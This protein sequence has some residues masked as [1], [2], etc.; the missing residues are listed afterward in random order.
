[1]SG[2]PVRVGR[3]GAV[4]VVEID[5]P[6]VNTM[7]DVVLEGLADA[8]AV[9]AGDAAVRA[10]VLTGAGKKAFASGADLR[11]F[12]A[13]LG[14]EDAI[15]HHT[16]LTRRA[17]GAIAALPQPTVAALQAS[18]VG[19]GLELALACDLLVADARAR[20]GLPETGLGLIPG[21]GGTQRLAR[22]IGTAAAFEL[23]ALGR[24]LGAEEAHA[25]GLLSA[26]AEPGGALARALELAGQL[27]ER[28]AQAVQAAKRAVMGGAE[29]DL[30]TGLDLERDCFRRV[31]RSDDAVAGVEAFLERRQPAFTHR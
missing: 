31:L 22:R 4:A 1:V 29:L 2:G 9:L 12:R 10:V 11:E 30:E 20:I 13:M 26:V 25:R 19:G 16:L 21:A 5:N 15:A 7:A 23:I 6:P 28:P 27:A 3:E 14:D 18:A 24:L 8:A 17:L